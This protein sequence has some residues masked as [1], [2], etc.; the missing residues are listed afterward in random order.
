MRNEFSLV[1]GVT[2]ANGQRNATSQKNILAWEEPSALRRSSGKGN[3]KDNA[4][5]AAL[6]VK[7]ASAAVLNI[8]ELDH[9]SA[10]AFNS[11]N[12]GQNYYSLNN[13]TRGSGVGSGVGLAGSPSLR[14]AR[15]ALRKSTSFSNDLSRCSPPFGTDDVGSPS[16]K[17]PLSYFER[18][19]KPNGARFAPTMEIA[20]GCG[21]SASAAAV[22]ASVS[23]VGRAGVRSTPN[24][25]QAR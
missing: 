10:S 2:V 25:F 15:T 6:I 22:A 9:Q 18:G 20:G 21:P 5:A 19:R 4:T 13:G 12:T 17:S 3:N 16:A 11:Y 23:P 8:G 14:P 1:G 7:K 24:A